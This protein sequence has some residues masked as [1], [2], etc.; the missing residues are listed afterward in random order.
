MPELPEVET[1]ARSLRA[2]S[3]GPA[4]PG[5][6]IA[7]ISSRWPRHFR[8]PSLR[9]FRRR[10]SGQAIQDVA[11][12]GKYLVFPLETETMLIHLRMSGDLR[13][14]PTEEP[15]ARFEHTLFHLDND[16]DLRFS[17]AR[18]FGRISLFRDPAG[19]L[20][21]L[22]P[23]PLDPEFSPA[24]L[25]QRLAGH[26]RMLKPLLLDQSF[27]A[28]IGNIYA[29]EALHFAHLHPLRRSDSLSMEEAVSLWE[30]I[31]RA[32]EA[33]LLH[34]GASIDWVYRGGDYQHH[35]RVYGRTGEPCPD[36]GNPVERIVVGQRGTHFCAQ[37]QLEVQE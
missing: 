6:R 27:L 1:I 30:G 13:L 19:F 29:D 14:A 31:H 8:E 32:L 11:R 36:C 28:G 10:I 16:W 22:G 18:K 15:R 23:E 5:R 21:R 9:T 34:N 33:G 24:V 25:A 26:K 3:G 4:L 12:R 37:C 20:S 17:D 2:G 35:F 7:G